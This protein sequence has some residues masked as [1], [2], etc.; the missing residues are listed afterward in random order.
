[1][2][3]ASALSVLGC[4]EK[5]LS[6]YVIMQKQDYKTDPFP[7]QRKAHSFYAVKYVTVVL[8]IGVT[9]EA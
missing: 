6:V 2:C 3:L 5:G 1:M 8:A 7:M 4:S 9:Y